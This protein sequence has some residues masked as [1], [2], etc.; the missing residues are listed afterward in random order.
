V[1]TLI[2]AASEQISSSNSAIVSSPMTTIVEHTY[3]SFPCSGKGGQR[4][5]DRPP[6]AVFVTTGRFDELRCL[7]PDAPRPG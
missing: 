3:D 1:A 7:S 6:R 4:S 2:R 5:C